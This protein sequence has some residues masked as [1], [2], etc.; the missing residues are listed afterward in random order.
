MHSLDRYKYDRKGESHIASLLDG[1]YLYRVTSLHH[2]NLEHALNGGGPANSNQ[3]GRFHSPQQRTSYCANNV[4]VC[5]A[6]V[7]YHM[8]RMALQGVEGIS[9]AAHIRSAFKDKRCLVVLRVSEIDNLVYIDADDVAYDFNVRLCRTATV[10]PDPRYEVISKLNNKLRS[11]NKRGV[12]YPSAR[13]S[14]DVCVALFQDETKRIETMYE[15]LTLDLCLLPESQKCGRD[16]RDID[17]HRDKIHPTMGYYA[18]EN[19]DKLNDLKRQGLIYPAKIPQ[20]GMIDFVRR[21]YD[22][23]PSKAVC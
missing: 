4:L 12:F 3:P 14:Q 13:H 9:E 10:F 23:Y 8:Y 17:L 20:R 22:D 7:L 2:A 15:V 16:P 1:A 11:Q 19:V 5:I 6:E 18:F 21:R